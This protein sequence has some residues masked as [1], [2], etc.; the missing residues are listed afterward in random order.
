MNKLYIGPGIIF[1][2]ISSLVFSENKIFI[3]Y[4]YIFFSHL[5]FLDFFVE[6][7]H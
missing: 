6:M 3:F 1:K 4:F 7:I 2:I 5:F